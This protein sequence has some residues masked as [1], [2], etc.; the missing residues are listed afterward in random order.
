VDLCEF[1]TSLM[2]RVS[3]KTARAIQ[4]DPV[5]KK[6]N[7]QTDRQTKVQHENSTICSSICKLKLFLESL[8][9]STVMQACTLPPGRLREKAVQVQSGLHSETLS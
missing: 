4:R 5:L 7:R 6:T 8:E 1:K 9:P 2:Y 3:F